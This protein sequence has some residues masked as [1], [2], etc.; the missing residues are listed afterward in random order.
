MLQDPQTAEDYQAGRVCY[1]LWF[2]HNILE[3]FVALCQRGNILDII[4]IHD[5]SD[6]SATNLVDPERIR[7]DA[8]HSP[9]PA[10]PL[11]TQSDGR[12]GFQPKPLVGRVGNQQEAE[13]LKLSGIPLCGEGSRLYSHINVRLWLIQSCTIGFGAPCPDSE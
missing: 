13:Y 11:K 7:A 5:E 1:V 10:L 2:S 6:N 9:R 4:A 3:R 8:Q 12:V